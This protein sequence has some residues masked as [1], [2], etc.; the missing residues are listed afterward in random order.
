MYRYFPFLFT[1]RTCSPLSSL[2][3]SLGSQPLITLLSSNAQSTD[4]TLLWTRFFWIRTRAWSTSGSSGITS[5]PAV[6]GVRANHDHKRTFF[7]LLPPLHG[8]R[9]PC[10][11]PA[12]PGMPGLENF[13]LSAD[14][15]S[16]A[17]PRGGR[18][19]LGGGRGRVRHLSRGGGRRQ[20]VVLVIQVIQNR[21]SSSSCAVFLG[22]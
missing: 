3:T 11:D 13:H 8:N 19:T 2:F 22:T 6:C 18:L 12:W 7:S 21:P 1:Y 17:Q 15:S 14:P 10:R 9:Q 20:Q 4:N 16:A 5:H